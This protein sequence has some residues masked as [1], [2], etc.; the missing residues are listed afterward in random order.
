MYPHHCIVKRRSHVREL[1]SF[2][3]SSS[4]SSV[5]CPVGLSIIVIGRDKNLPY[6]D[7]CKLDNQAKEE[8][9]EEVENKEEDRTVEMINNNNNSSE[10]SSPPPIPLPS[11]TTTSGHKLHDDPFTHRPLFLALKRSG[12]CV[13]YVEAISHSQIDIQ[14]VKVAL[15][16][17]SQDPVC[18][19]E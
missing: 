10:F 7:G 4:S 12:L 15:L 2:S 13:E 1:F 5:F 14:A 11:T 16:R 6:P 3:S 19:H 17:S 18:S 8:A 9:E